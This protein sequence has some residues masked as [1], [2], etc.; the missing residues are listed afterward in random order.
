[1]SP[2]CNDRALGVARIAVFRPTSSGLDLRRTRV[3]LPFGYRDP[4]A[5]MVSAKAL[6]ST[7]E[8]DNALVHSHGA[9]SPRAGGRS[10]LL[11]DKQEHKIGLIGFPLKPK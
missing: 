8:E 5:Q 4:V 7:A 9:R 10:N 3:S 2:P 6:P 11:L 1:M